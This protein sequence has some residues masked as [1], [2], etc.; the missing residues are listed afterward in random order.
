MREL[1]LQPQT[2]GQFEQQVFQLVRADLL[3]AGLNPMSPARAE[4]VH[5]S[6]R[7]PTTVTYLPR[8]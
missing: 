1:L 4:I 8:P 3:Q 2:R 6:S 5:S 7:A